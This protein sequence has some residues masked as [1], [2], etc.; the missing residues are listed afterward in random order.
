MC[1]EKNGNLVEAIQASRVAYAKLLKVA[2]GTQHWTL[3]S[4]KC[5]QTKEMDVLSKYH[6]SEIIHGQYSSILIYFYLF[7][8]FAS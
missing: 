3:E 8:L 4:N 1:F 2:W 7:T 5:N 6:D